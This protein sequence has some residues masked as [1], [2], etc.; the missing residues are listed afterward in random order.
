MMLF[1]MAGRIPVPELIKNQMIK[2]VFLYFQSLEPTKMK[3]P[4]TIYSLHILYNVERKI[5]CETNF[6]FSTQAL[7]TEHST[8]QRTIRFFVFPL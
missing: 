8:V 5:N 3:K 1:S 2:G 7:N 4:L 6:F